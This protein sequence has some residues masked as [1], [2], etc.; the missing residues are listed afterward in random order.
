[1]TPEELRSR[2]AALG[3]SQLAIAERLG[4]P[5]NTWARWERGELAV[6][7]PVLLGLALEALAARAG[8]ERAAG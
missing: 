5:R 4:I 6:E 7:K 8:G 2:R 1:M 3:L